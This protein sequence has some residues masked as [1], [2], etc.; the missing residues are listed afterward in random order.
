MNIYN[1]ECRACYPITGGTGWCIG[2]EK[3]GLVGS[4]S[5]TAPFQPDGQVYSVFPS[6]TLPVDRA[7]SIR[8]PTQ[9]VVIVVQS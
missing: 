3:N 7:P 5:Q 8:F 1:A 4:A 6:Q 9:P 2:C